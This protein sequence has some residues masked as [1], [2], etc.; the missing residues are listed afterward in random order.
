MGDDYMPQQ[1][2]QSYYSVL[3]TPNNGPITKQNRKKSHHATEAVR[4]MLVPLIS[5]NVMHSATC[6]APNATAGWWQLTYLQLDFNQQLLL[7]KK[8]NKTK[9]NIK[10]KKNTH[11]TNKT[12]YSLLCAVNKL[13][14]I[15]SLESSLYSF[16]SP[17]SFCVVI[18]HLE[19]ENNSALSSEEIIRNQPFL[20]L[21][22]SLHLCDCVYVCRKYLQIW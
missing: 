17:Q 15:G 11:K 4:R 1:Y 8:A 7:E 3:F 9:L 5:P 10:K 14:L 2:A 19:P 16:I 13:V 6:L 21:F 12:E 20:Q 22:L 18:K